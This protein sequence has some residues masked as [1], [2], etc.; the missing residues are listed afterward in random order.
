MNMASTSLTTPKGERKDKDNP[1]EKDLETKVPI[2][3]ESVYDTKAIT[4]DEMIEMYEAVKY[5]G[6]DRNLML[7]KLYEKLQDK[8]LCIQAIIACAINGPT[9][10]AKVRLRNGKTLEEMGI[11]ASKQQKT[12]NLSCQRITACTADLAAYY[13]KKLDVPKRIVDD[14]CPAWLQFPAAG[15]IKMP[16]SYREKHISFSKRFSKLISQGKDNFNDSIYSQM[17]ANAYLDE[18]LKL[19]I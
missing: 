18:K 3:I 2:W 5:H 14:E 12:E 7:K 10:A 16:Q 6:F 1:K 17:M 11:P 4:D 19:F 15:S 13:M 8:K 9:R